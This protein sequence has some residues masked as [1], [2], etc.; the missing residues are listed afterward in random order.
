MTIRAVLDASAL[1]ALVRREPGAEV[2]ASYLPH[3]VISTVNLSEVHAKLLTLG[4]ALEPLE[5]DLGAMG[6]TVEP[7]TRADARSTAELRALTRARGLS[8]ADRACLALAW[9]LGVPAL[10]ADHPWGDLEGLPVQVELIR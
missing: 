10:T 6:V 8:L 7:F 3:A 1:L 5:R 9:R 4:L 2:V